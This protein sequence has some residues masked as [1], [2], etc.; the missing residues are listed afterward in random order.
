MKQFTLFFFAFFSLLIMMSCKDDVSKQL[1][2]NKQT[3]TEEK[4]LICFPKL[5]LQGSRS[6]Q[7]ANDW[8]NWSK[9]LLASGEEAFTPWN[10]VTGTDIPYDVRTDI[11]K[12]DGW[13][14]IF[15]T[16]NGY[17]T[18]NMN[19][20]I[21]HNRYTG[22]LKGFYYLEDGSHLQ[23]TG[24]WKIHFERPQAFLNFIDDFAEPASINKNS[25]FYVSNIT[26]NESI[27]FSLGWNCF[28]VELAYDPNFS[29]IPIQ[30]SPYNMT[31]TDVTI[32]GEF[33]SSTTG[34]IIHT[35]SSNIFDKQIK[36]VASFAGKEAKNWVNEALK[37]DVFK[38]IKGQVI[39]AAGDIVT[40]GV[41]S[42]LRSFLG[43]FDKEKNEVQTVQLRTNGTITMNGELS[44]VETGI[45]MPLSTVLTVENVGKLGAWCIKESPILEFSPIA[46]YTG[47]GD[48]EIHGKYEL[49]NWS[50]KF[51]GL[52]NPDLVSHI[53]DCKFNY[54]L[55][56]SSKCSERHNIP[57]PFQYGNNNHIV[58]I[59]IG[60]FLK[61]NQ[62]YDDVYSMRC[63]PLTVHLG[64]TSTPPESVYVIDA[65][66]GTYGAVGNISFSPRH[67]VV[68]EMRLT[69]DVEGK[70]HT[71]VS[72]HTF[73]IT[74]YQWSQWSNND[75][76]YWPFTK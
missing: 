23:N 11:K 46:H 1:D 24:M 60:E 38:K 42:L 41:S 32:D 40:S 9:V 28:Q 17:G 22:V 13:E 61:E 34:T 27:G 72:S 2:N 25:D 14:L 47:N 56:E 18:K 54:T 49:E 73:D 75:K 59:S 35:T 48:E 76:S 30:I 26:N 64:L 15:H 21:F 7:D 66:D 55:Y 53:K 69:V 31:T 68:I 51:E 16:V 36:G 29:S 33:E 65:P 44:K 45:I 39:N 70:E 37:S 3:M 63:I 57:D 43:G 74:K 12:A 71:Y 62:L 52:L 58:P 4:G 19:Y 8:E 20:L 5:A 10:S 67:I 50:V 6:E